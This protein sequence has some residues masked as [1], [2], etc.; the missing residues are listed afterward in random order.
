M[1]PRDVDRPPAPAMA[2][3]VRLAADTPWPLHGIDGSRTIEASAQATRPQ[4]ALMERAG[5]AVARLGLA[6][7]PHARR[8]WVACGPGNNGGDGLVAARH[9]AAAGKDV[10]ITL[11]GDPQRLPPD[12]AAAWRALH[13]STARVVAAA[14]ELDHGDL[15]IDALL[16][17]GA[18]RAPEG[19][20]AERVGQF[21]ACSAT[22]LAID[23]PTGLDAD[24]GRA[25][26]P[27]I[28]QADHTLT[29]LTAKPGLFTAHGRDS[30]GCVW[31]DGLG[32]PPP[33]HAE[34]WLSP[35]RPAAAGPRRHTSHKGSFGDVLVVGGAP[36]LRG[37]AVLAAGAAHGAGAGR[38]YLALLGAESGPAPADPPIRPELMLRTRPH[39]DAPEAWARAV[40]VCGCGGG[41]PVHA[42]LPHWLAHSMALVLDADALNA[43]A[44]DASLQRALARR[45]SLGRPS[46]MTPHPLEAARL[47]ASTADAVQ[48]DR[49][50][51]ARAIAER[52][53]SVVVLKGSGSIVAAPGEP[54][55]INASGSAALASAGTGDVLAG[56]IGGRWAA[57]SGATGS[58]AGSGAAAARALAVTREAVL[59]HG[60]IGAAAGSGP[61]RALDLSEAMHAHRSGGCR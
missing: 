17:L 42:V 23:L 25:L 2:G 21:N 13:G 46:V 24:T 10:A 14:P 35:A 61:A 41:E 32:I 4:P 56:W 43:I 29:L 44:G 18:R 39:A 11:D 15:A 55:W 8:V 6:V 60:W 57:E 36:G 7:A 33:A 38:V 47:L 54:P 31:F 27:A 22:R 26:G 3:I 20:L 9:L 37:A 34:A 1:P 5:H 53:G 51:A 48:A 40:V 58:P 50:G 12:A 28:V 49:L 30:A 16:G 59:L 19:A 45:H 52:F